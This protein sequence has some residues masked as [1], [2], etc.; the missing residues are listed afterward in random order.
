VRTLPLRL[1]PIEEESLPG[2]LHRYA[3]TFGI[4]PADTLRAT[5]LLAGRE[6]LGAS[7]PYPLRLSDEQAARFATAT[8][9]DQ[10]Q[11]SRM[12]LSRFEGTAFAMPASERSAKQPRAMLALEISLWKTRACP[13]CL[14]TDGAWRLRWL[15]PWSILC[16]RHE[17]LLLSRCPAC[18]HRLH[19]GRRAGWPYDEHGPEQGATSCWQSAHGRVCRYPLQDADSSHVEGDQLLLAAQRRID[20]ILDGQTKPV[21]AGNECEPLQYLRDL[22]ALIR[23]AQGEQTPTEEHTRGT[24]KQTT[25]D[26]QPSARTLADPARVAPALGKALAMADMP[27]PDALC[28]SIRALADARYAESGRPLA[29]LREFRAISPLMRKAIMDA[30]QTASYANVAARFGFDP[31]RHRRPADLHPDLRPRHVPQL[32][33]RDDYERCRRR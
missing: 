28:D 15:L 30:A 2:Y 22:R 20:L 32:Y 13:G 8:A 5:G 27:H 26:P 25:G 17:R 3:C 10:G 6:R 21:L 29:R 33:W 7:G 23:L 14:R 19:F 9:L 31:R 16:V 18:Q 12:L 11:V 24:G 1:P 4:P